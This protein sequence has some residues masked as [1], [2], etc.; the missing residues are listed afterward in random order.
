MGSGW[1]VVGRSL[2][3][4]GLAK[5]LALAGSKGVFCLAIMMFVL[6]GFQRFHKICSELSK[7]T[8]LFGFKFREPALVHPVVLAWFTL[9]TLKSGG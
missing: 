4:V 2:L 3:A 1:E 9:P 7:F 5:P 6:K 8:L